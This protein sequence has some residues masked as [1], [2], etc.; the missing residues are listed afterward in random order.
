MGGDEMAKKTTK[1]AVKKTTKKPVAKKAL[2][3][4][5]ATPVKK[6]AVAPVARDPR[7]PPVGTT[8]HAKYKGKAYEALVTDAGI[9]VGKETF[10]SVSAAGKSITGKSTNGYVFFGLNG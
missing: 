4:K 8:I 7:L 5:K 9:K 1:K 3:C 2:P 10:K 6:T